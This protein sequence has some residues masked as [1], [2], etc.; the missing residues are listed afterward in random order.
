MNHPKLPLLPFRIRESFKKTK[1]KSNIEPPEGLELLLQ[2][3]EAT[4]N[5]E[6]SATTNTKESSFSPF[7]VQVI[8]LSEQ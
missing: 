5:K 7:S 6:S 8:I 2:V 3:I 4:S 1:P